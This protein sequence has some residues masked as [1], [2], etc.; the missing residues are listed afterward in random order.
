MKCKYN[1]ISHEDGRTHYHYT[2]VDCGKEI[3]TLWAKSSEVARCIGCSKIHMKNT[4]KNKS[5]EEKKAIQNKIQRSKEINRQEKIQELGEEKFLEIEKEKY[6]ERK[7]K[8]DKTKIERYGSL[9]NLNKLVI[10]KTRKTLKKKYGVDRICEIPGVKEK[11]IKTNLEKYG[12]DNPSKNN[13]I[14]S[15]IRNTHL[16]KTKEEKKIIL[17]K[18]KKTNLEKYGTEF[19]QRSDAVK[20]RYK[21]NCLEKY[22]VDNTSK[23]PETR[24][25]TH[26]TIIEKYGSWKNTKTDDSR[27][28]KREELI[29]EN[30]RKYKNI[31]FLSKGFNYFEKDGRPFVKCLNCGIEF[32]LETPPSQIMTN[33][34][35]PECNPKFRGSQI[36]RDLANFIRSLDT[37]VIENTRRIL[38][39]SKELDIYLPD[40]NLAIEY[41]GSFW[42]KYVP[43]EDFRKGTRFI[44]ISDKKYH[45]KKTEECEKK[46]IRL[47]HIFDNEYL[48]KN[49]IVESLIKK[50]LNKELNKV[51]ARKCKI[52]EVDQTAYR[53][54]LEENHLQ[55]Y[56]N[57]TIKLGLFY[58][59][60][61]VSILGMSRSRYNKKVEWELIRYCEK[62][63]IVILGGK[64]KLLKFFIKKYN[65]SSIISYSDR[66]WFT[67]KSLE[68]IGFKYIGS[69]SPNYK[70]FKV[71]FFDFYSRES[72]QKYKMKEMKNFIYN[73]KLTEIE[74]MRYN[75]Y[76]LIYDCGMNVYI[77]E[78]K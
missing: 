41:D 62:K 29:W 3:I 34:H 1:F 63:D 57:T 7:E 22:G 68:S 59:G 19:A 67:G 27:R 23:L 6:K 21:N 12:V 71:G 52:R 25:K 28:L 54:F 39:D 44:G 37:K 45:L 61:L 11:I 9:E 31:D 69:T 53:K 42:H 65:P 78:K 47:I 33:L 43:V 51:G 56:V 20:K 15:K 75:G 48:L 13:E 32:L 2:C 64:N 16:I 46:G 66:R 60:K 36:Q 10:D 24:I 50:F 49:D 76:D 18:R 40:Y 38:K 77:W 4:F 35:C 26:N 74:N 73:E 8:S 14:S 55:G 5:I 58:E 70:Y 72:F 17:E 30:M